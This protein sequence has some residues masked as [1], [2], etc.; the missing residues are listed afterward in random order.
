MIQ[1]HDDIFGKD[2]AGVSKLLREQPHLINNLSYTLAVIKE[3][4]RLYPVAS[5]IRSG[6]PEYVQLHLLS[7]DILLTIP[8]IAFSCMTSRL[9]T[10]IQLS[11]IQLYG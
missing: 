7:P 8:T 1:E 2:L 11:T 6:G 9:V 10:A 3:S 5:T 4:L